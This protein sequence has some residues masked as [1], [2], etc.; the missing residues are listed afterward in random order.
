MLN[1]STLL[2]LFS[3]CFIQSVSHKV[4]YCL[5]QCVSQDFSFICFCVYCHMKLDPCHS[6]IVCR[7]IQNSGNAAYHIVPCLRYLL[8]LQTKP[9]NQST[10]LS[11]VLRIPVYFSPRYILW[12]TATDLYT[13]QK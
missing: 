2:P 3:N 6:A 13:P 5:F 10:I 7:H 11:R 8:G 1:L 9:L 12:N 4:K